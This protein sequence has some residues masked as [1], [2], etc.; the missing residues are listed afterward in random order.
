M[1]FDGV[2]IRINITGSMLLQDNSTKYDKVYNSIPLE[3]YNLDIESHKK[4][5]SC[6]YR[7]NIRGEMTDTDVQ[8]YGIPLYDSEYENRVYENNKDFTIDIPFKQVVK[9][10]KLDI[11]NKIPKIR[12]FINEILDDLAVELPSLEFSNYHFK[13]HSP[14][15]EDDDKLSYRKEHELFWK[16]IQNPEYECACCICTIE[17]RFKTECGHTLCL[18]CHFKLKIENEDDDDEPATR[19]CPMC[20]NEYSEINWDEEH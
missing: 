7:I 6:I 16:K 18:G 4:L 5:N 14:A 10:S 3:S 2:K 19:K 20:R 13:L 15:N 17:S 9:L 8:K 12:G 11:F 1:K